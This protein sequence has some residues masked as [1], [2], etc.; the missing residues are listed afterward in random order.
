MIRNFGLSFKRT[1]SKFLE[2]L[3]DEDLPQTSDAVL[4]MV[5]YE[6]ALTSFE[7]RYDRVVK[8]KHNEYDTRHIWATEQRIASL[9][10]DEV[11]G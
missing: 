1:V 3:N 9:E 5:Q 2:L 10:D 11:L 4:I 7:N 8:K 6:S